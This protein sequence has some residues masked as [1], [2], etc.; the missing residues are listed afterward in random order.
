MEDIPEGD[1]YCYACISKVQLS[2]DIFPSEQDRK[3]FTRNI[4]TI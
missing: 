1:W 2:E 3:E 4:E